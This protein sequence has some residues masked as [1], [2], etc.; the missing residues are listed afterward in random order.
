MFVKA[1]KKLSNWNANQGAHQRKG[2]KP[3]IHGQMLLSDNSPRLGGLEDVEEPETIDLKPFYTKDDLMEPLPQFRETNPEDRQMLLMKKLRMCSVVFDFK[4]KTARSNLGKEIKRQ[5]LLEMVD[6]ITTDTTWFSEEATVEMLDMVASNIFRPLPPKREKQPWDTDEE[7]PKLDDAWPHLQIIYEFLLRFVISTEVDTKFLK[8][9]IK[10]KF[11]V[12]MLDLFDTNDPRERD[13][14]KTILHRIY[15]RFMSMRS[16]IRRAIN[17]IFFKVM[18]RDVRHNGIAEL[19]EILG[20]IINGFALP[21]KTEHKQF[22]RNVL[23]PL[24]KLPTLASFHQQLTICVTQFI[25][26]DS[27]LSGP[28]VLSFL[29]FWPRTSSSKEVIFLNEMEEILELCTT[30][31]ILQVHEP[32]FRAIAKSVQSQ[33]FQVAERALFLWNNDIIAGFTHDY[34]D[35]VLP[36][37][38]PA[39]HDNNKHHWNAAVHSLTFNIVKMFLELDQVLFKSVCEDFQSAFSGIAKAKEQRFYKWEKIREIARENASSQPNLEEKIKLQIVERP[40]PLALEKLEPPIQMEYPTIEER[41]EQH[42]SE[43]EIVNLE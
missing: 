27:S 8:K 19:L 25:E 4:N 42:D 20:S 3:A 17:H 39:L 41:P 26:K 34:R 32:L 10:G 5:M 38:Y 37:L 31:Q 2:K 35:K 40:Y 7:E 24:H 30:E 43:Q 23:V 18:Y 21:L 16:F 12:S 28:V 14:L 1:K 22:L 15:G 36:L 9:H 33:H 13:Y 11:I 6:F 29:H